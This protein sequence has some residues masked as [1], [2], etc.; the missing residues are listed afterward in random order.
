MRS[1]LTQMQKIVLSDEITAAMD[2]HYATVSL[3]YFFA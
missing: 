1:P 3:N 2:P